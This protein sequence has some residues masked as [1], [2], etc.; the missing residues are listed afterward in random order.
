MNAIT[1]GV[2]GFSRADVEVAEGYEMTIMGEMMAGA[3]Q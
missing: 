3:G 1:P 2:D